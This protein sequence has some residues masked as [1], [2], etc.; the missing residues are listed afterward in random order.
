[1][2]RRWLRSIIAHS[3]DPYLIAVGA[4]KRRR[5]ARLARAMAVTASVRRA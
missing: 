5:G 2:T 4:R 1:M 3:G